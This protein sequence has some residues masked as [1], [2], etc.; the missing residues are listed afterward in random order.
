MQIPN[1]LDAWSHATVVDCAKIGRCE[2]ER[3]DFKFNL[4][5]SDTLTKVC[6]AFSNSYGGFVVV[7]VKDR[8]GHFTV[9]GIAPD[10]EIAKKFSDKL[11]A[12]PSIQFSS[13]RSI[14]VP[15]TSKFL[16]IF[17]VPQSPDRPHIPMQVDKRIFWKR[18]PGGC[19]QMTF[20]EIQEQFLRYEERREKLKLLFIE[21]LCNREQLQEMS[22]IEKGKYSLATLDSAVLDHLLVDTFS[23]VS[24]EVGLIRILLTLRNEIRIT[25]NKAKIFF[26]QMAMPLSNRDTLA[27]THNDF[28]AEKVAFLTPLIDQAIELLKTRFSLTDPFGDEN[29]G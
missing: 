27:A 22:A 17:H 28:M 12:D 9:E 8:S 25:N 11:H 16:Y 1:S 20:K 2:G 13:P 3:H 4:P 14:A 6:C 19:E 7:G 10:S 24:T 23:I 26:L 29:G 15:E 5:D 18:T 21:L